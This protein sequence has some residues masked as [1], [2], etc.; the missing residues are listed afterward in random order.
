MRFN[1][2]LSALTVFAALGLGVAGCRE[3][4]AASA[5]H[6]TPAA[7]YGYNPSSV[8]GTHAAQSPN[9][10]PKV[11]VEG[12]VAAG[13]TRET[14]STPSAIGGGPA[15]TPT[16]QGEHRG[17]LGTESGVTIDDGKPSVSRTGK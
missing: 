17:H 11:L 8:D 2:T 14:A 10:A 3:D 7:W 5:Y 9:V 13:N 12:E 15:P 4:R 1:T 6:P 16:F